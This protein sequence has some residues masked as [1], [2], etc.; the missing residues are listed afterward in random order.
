MCQVGE[1]WG[2]DGPEV[3]KEESRSLVFSWDHID[4]GMEDRPKRIESKEPLDSG[5]G[6]GGRQ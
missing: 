1:L 2:A 6:L 4:N 5:S 3:N